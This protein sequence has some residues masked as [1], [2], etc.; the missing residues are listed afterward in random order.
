MLVLVDF[1]CF[2]KETLRVCFF[3]C[4][5][6]LPPGGDTRGHGQCHRGSVVASQTS[7]RSVVSAGF[8][9]NLRTGLDFCIMCVFFFCD[10]SDFSRVRERVL[11]FVTSL[12]QAYCRTPLRLIALSCVFGV[13]HGLWDL[14]ALRTNQRGI[15]PR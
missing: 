7:G 1:C 3:M 10:R 6:S 14:C 2:R 8:A 11:L 9:Y 13:A 12:L 4:F 5:G 15:H